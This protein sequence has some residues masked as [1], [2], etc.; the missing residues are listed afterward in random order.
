MSPRQKPNH[1][2]TTEGSSPASSANA[3]SSDR[4]LDNL[5]RHADNPSKWE[6]EATANASTVSDLAAPHSIFFFRQAPAW[7]RKAVLA[8]KGKACLITF[9]SLADLDACAGALA[10]AQ[11]LGPKAVIAPPDRINSE[12]RRLLANETKNW[13]RFEQA[14][15][16]HPGAPVILLDAND[17][18]ILPQFKSNGAA[19]A[20]PSPTVDILIDHHASMAASIRAATSWIDPDASSNCE[21][22]AHLI[23]NPSPEQARWLA[24]GLLSDSARLS[25]ADAETLA[26]LSRLLRACPDSYEQLLNQLQQP[27][28]AASRAAVLEGLRSAAWQQSGELLVA[29]AAVSSHESHVADA[30]VQAGA[31]AAFAGV[32]QVGPTPSQ[33]GARISARLRPALSSRVD[34]PAL[35]QKTGQL[36]GGNG[37]GHP[38]AAGATGPKAEKLE[39]ALTLA[40][41]LFLKEAK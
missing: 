40:Q 2:K 12:S 16:S 17:P 8:L 22:V 29:T 15:K 36:L 33:S 9:H 32:A 7:V 24:L 23:P 19:R 38:C 26:M 18:S 20:S 5:R 37:G 11:E 41:E 3:N 14:Q 31:D 30:L 28:S 27:A 25:R 13:S 35:M 34:L 4:K 1:G 21:L 10:L 6:A 39:Q